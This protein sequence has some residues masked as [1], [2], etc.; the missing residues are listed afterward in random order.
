MKAMQDQITML[1]ATVRSPV[2]SDDSTALG[3]YLGSATTSVTS[4]YSLLPAQR[5]TR[6]LST[7]RKAPFQGPTT[8]AFSF[9]LARSASNGGT[10]LSAM[11]LV[12]RGTRTKSRRR[13][14]LITHWSLNSR[15]TRS[16]PYPKATPSDSRA[17]TKKRWE[18]CIQ[19]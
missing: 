11:K 4:T 2:R 12:T 7:A 16:G 5:S 10:S 17:C 6:P 14:H 13:Q 18:L 9:D 3:P 8:S 1:S 15:S 19:C